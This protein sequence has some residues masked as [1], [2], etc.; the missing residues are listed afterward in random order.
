MA[1]VTTI[2]AIIGIAVKGGWFTSAE[3]ADEILGEWGDRGEAT[4]GLVLQ[5]ENQT[6]TIYPELRDMRDEAIDKFSDYRNAAPWNKGSTADKYH[7]KVQ[8]LSQAIEAEAKLYQEKGM[9]GGLTSFVLGVDLKTILFVGVGII[10]VL[11]VLSFILRRKR[12]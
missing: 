6:E 2:S 4:G 3:F 8:E 12:R 10:V 11:L 9:F 1:I 7:Q 5:L